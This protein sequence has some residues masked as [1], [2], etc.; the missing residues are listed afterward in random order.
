MNLESV[1]TQGLNLLGTFS[2]QIAL[3]LFLVCFIGEAAVSVP[4]L[5]E[6]TWLLVGYQLGADVLDPKNFVLLLLAA[7]LGRQSGAL[8]MY[9]FS[10]TATR[11]L[12]KF[13]RHVNWKLDAS[14]G[15]GGRIARGM[16]SL[17]PFSVALGRLVALRIPLTLTLAAR[18]KWKVLC[19]GVFL[20]SLVWEAT[21][22]VLGAVVGATTSVKPT[23]LLLYSVSG[24][25]LLY[26]V[27][28]VLRRLWGGLRRRRSQAGLS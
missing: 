19:L 21:Y 10:R 15:I 26:V 12:Q 23:H 5:L 7:Q 22:I 28:L 13:G 14:S 3:F 24:L 27:T 1:L 9:L 25:T 6:T 16:D 11:L 20:S 4:Y 8:V 2:P 18:G 17:S